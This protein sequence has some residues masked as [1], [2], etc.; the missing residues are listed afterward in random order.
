MGNAMT[1]RLKTELTLKRNISRVKQSGVPD[2]I[3]P[4]KTS[5]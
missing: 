5:L 4:K 1:T 3:E 2:E